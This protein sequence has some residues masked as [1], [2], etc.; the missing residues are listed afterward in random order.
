MSVPFFK[1]RVQ[2]DALFGINFM[3]LMEPL[4]TTL[5]VASTFIPSSKTTGGDARS[6]VVFEKL[7][8]ALQT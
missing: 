7:P 8:R 5:D 4:E 6:N 1:K 2:A 3:R